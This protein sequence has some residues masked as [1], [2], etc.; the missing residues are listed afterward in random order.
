MYWPW[1]YYS[2]ILYV[3]AFVVRGT[4]SEYLNDVHEALRE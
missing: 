1:L 4:L 2:T 3:A